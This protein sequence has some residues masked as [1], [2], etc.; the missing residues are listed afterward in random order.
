MLNPKAKPYPLS[1][2][3]YVHGTKYT[4]LCRFKKNEIKSMK[5]KYGQIVQFR[6]NI[7]VIT[8]L[9]PFRRPELYL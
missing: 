2:V 1:R 9:S 7:V 8:S 6:D 4:F 3:K 5:S